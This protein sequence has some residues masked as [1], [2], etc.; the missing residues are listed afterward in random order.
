M[1]RINGQDKFSLFEFKSKGIYHSGSLSR[2]SL[3]NSFRDCSNR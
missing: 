1:I 3:T 2:M